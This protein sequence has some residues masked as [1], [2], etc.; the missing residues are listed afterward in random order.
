[1]D[2]RANN[3]AYIDSQ[4]LNLGIQDCGWKLDY[5]KFRVYLAEKYSIKTAYLF[6]GFLPQNQ[7]LYSSLQKNGYILKFKPVLPNR[8]GSHKGNIDADMVLQIIID[9]FERNFDKALIVTSDGDFYSTVKFLYDKEKLEKVISP[10]YK[11][12]S[13]LLRS[14]AKEKLIFIKNLQNKL[15]YIKKN[16]A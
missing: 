16:T 10:Y 3:Y 1:M 13:S 14:T 4:N 15:G 11:T 6:I 2:K 9:Y 12:C 7:D 5:R 8:D